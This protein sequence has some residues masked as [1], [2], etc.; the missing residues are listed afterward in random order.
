MGRRVELDQIGNLVEELQE[1]IDSTPTTQ[2][3]GIGCSVCGALA[4]LPGN[5]RIALH[6]AIDSR[7]GAVKLS[8]ILQANGVRVGVPS[9]R[10]HRLEG[11]K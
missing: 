2:P 6:N 1:G 9:I 11:H 5:E 7:I 10:R 4:V 8:R 3:Y